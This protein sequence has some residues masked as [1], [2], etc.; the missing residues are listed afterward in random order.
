MEVI[1]QIHDDIQRAEGFCH[2]AARGASQDEQC[3]EGDSL[4]H[5]GRMRGG[6][7]LEHKLIAEEA[8]GRA[9]SFL[10]V[11]ECSKGMFTA[12]CACPGW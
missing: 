7:R 4:F 11:E 5:K 3:D 6:L 10:L 12:R 8:T 1:G 2:G 9:G